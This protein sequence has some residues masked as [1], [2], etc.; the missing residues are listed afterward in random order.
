MQVPRDINNAV[1]NGKDFFAKSYNDNEFKKL[2]Q[3]YLPYRLLKDRYNLP[4]FE[5]YFIL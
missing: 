4:Y 2:E 3:D 5:V 1:V